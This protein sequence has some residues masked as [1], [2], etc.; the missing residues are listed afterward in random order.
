MASNRHLSRIAVVQA[1][2]AWEFRGGEPEAILEYVLE[3]FYP[4]L[5]SNEFARANFKGIIEKRESIKE[6]ISRTAPEWEF[7]KI[8]AID[9]VVLEL[10]VY[11][12]LESTDVPPVVAINEAIE[13]AKQVGSDNSPKFINGV[14]STVM[15]AYKPNENDQR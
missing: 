2:F 12:I 1:L 9:R 7:E 3:Q 8:A 5:D 6:I 4:K 10:G 13:V 14:L 11:E 15:K